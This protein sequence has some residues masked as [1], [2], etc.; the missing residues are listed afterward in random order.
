MDQPEDFEKLGTNPHQVEVREEGRCDGG[1]PDPNE[2]WS[3][4]AALDD[5]TKSSSGSVRRTPTTW[6]LKTTPHGTGD[7]EVQLR[8]PRDVERAQ[9]Q[10]RAGYAAA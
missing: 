3:F 5:G 6:A 10:F 2:V 4:D 9:D 8:T 1:N 7:L